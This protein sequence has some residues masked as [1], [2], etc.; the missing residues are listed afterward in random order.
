MM[1]LVTVDAEAAV[2]AP[3]LIG[4]PELL[5]LLFV[6]VLAFLLVLPFWFVC[7]KAGVSPWLSCLVLV[8]LGV[9]VLPFILA[10]IDWPSLSQSSGQSRLHR[11]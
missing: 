7:K 4:T 10:L 3:R 9:F 2:A 8:P 11:S 6:P 1:H 5:V